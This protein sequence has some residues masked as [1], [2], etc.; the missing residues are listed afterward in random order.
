MGNQ[1]DQSK[2]PTSSGTV[3]LIGQFDF[4]FYIHGTS[5]LKVT[6]F[7]FVCSQRR[8]KRLNVLQLV[9]IKSATDLLN[10]NSL[11]LIA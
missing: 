11:I 8:P 2:S 3:I 5:N 10:V 9:V 7:N 6:V 1:T 4:L